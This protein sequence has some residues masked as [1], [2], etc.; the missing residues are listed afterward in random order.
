VA[1][2]HGMLEGPCQGLEEPARILRQILAGGADAILTTYGLA[3]R[4]ARDI[5]P[6]GLIMRMDGGSTIIGTNKGPGQAM[7]S[8]ED[9]LRVDADAIALS[10]FPGSP[11]EEHTLVQ[12]A[13]IVGHAHAWGM[14]VLAEMVPGGFDSAPE[15]RT[16]ANIALSARVAAELGADIVKTSNTPGFEAVAGTCYVPVVVLG[17]ARRGD[18]RQML[19]EIEAALRAGASGVAIGRNIFQADDPERMTRAL[20]SM[21][22]QNASAE[23]AW[24]ILQG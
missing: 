15:F 5:A 19:V 9:A 13:G 24:E 12:L 17:G 23:E 22:H 8:V 14:P 11:A 7:F 1:L 4:F 20:S 18:V 3:T 6:L 10:A 2:D 21:I 16:A